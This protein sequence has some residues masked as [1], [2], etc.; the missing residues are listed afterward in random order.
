M[1]AALSKFYSR[2]FSE[3]ADICSVILKREGSNESAWL[4]KMRALT[5][6]A[7]PHKDV[8]DMSFSEC[9][10][11]NNFKSG[12]A[13]AAFSC[14]V[15]SSGLMN[16]MKPS[17]LLE[18]PQT[19]ALRCK[20]SVKVSGCIERAIRSGRV[21]RTGAYTGRARTVNIT[22][23]RSA[24]MI[25]GEDGEFIHVA[26]LNLIKYSKRPDIAKCLF[27]YLCY[28]ADDVKSALDLSNLVA[29]KQEPV[30]DSESKVN[31]E[32]KLMLV[33]QDPWWKLQRAK[34]FVRL[35]ML[36]EAE[37]EC[38][39]AIQ[40]QPNTEIYIILGM[41]ALRSDQPLR[42]I[43][44][45]DNGLKSFPND[46]ELIT[47]KAQVYE[48]ISDLAMSVSLYKEIVKQDP[49]NFEA[50]ASVGA[51][52]FHDEQPEV[53][54]QFYRRLLLLGFRSTELFNNLA[55]CGYYGQQYDVCLGYMN[56][57]LELCRTENAA[58]VYFNVAH[59]FMGL[60][61]IS[62]AEQ[63]LRIALAYDSNYFEAYTNLGVLAEQ[64]GDTE[65]AK[66]FYEIAC[67]QAPDAFEPNHNLAVLTYR[68]G[69]LQ[70]SYQ[71]ANKTLSVFPNN[72]NMLR[73]LKDLEHYFK[74]T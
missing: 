28:V 31:I 60:G 24:S 74:S 67:Q 34:C 68:L 14:D 30:E 1:N 18:R 43:R 23:G 13:D 71:L 26:R 44:I 42:A 54:L 50:L 25:P 9:I 38:N 2:D 39:E 47:H 48:D 65:S 72:A 59:I 40:L 4:L 61:D 53:A 12:V 21:F 22:R 46:I 19:G 10:F 3:C 16:L 66:M 58:D 57:A 52:Y 64:R 55:L 56:E 69:D 15:P 17:K 36:R 20:S 27:E 51:F 5:E 11:K 63:A 70:T 33:G 62:Q 32:S 37:T 7:I 73:L 35:G 29:Q 8:L 41:I 49:G 6:L 45:Y